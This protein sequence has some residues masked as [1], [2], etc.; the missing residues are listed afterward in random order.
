MKKKADVPAKDVSQI[1]AGEN[2]MGVI[3]III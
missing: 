2:P 3:Q 1:I